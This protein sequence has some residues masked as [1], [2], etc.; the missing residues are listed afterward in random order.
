MLLSSLKKIKCK[1]LMVVIDIYRGS[2]FYLNDGG[3]NFRG[4]KKYYIHW[5]ENF[6]SI[7][8]NC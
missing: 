1:L 8:K 4:C 6:Y 2:V 7:S 3:Y 5:S